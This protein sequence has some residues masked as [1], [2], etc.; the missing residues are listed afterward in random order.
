MPTSDYEQK[1]ES[2]IRMCSQAKESGVDTVIIHHPEV[3]G[4]N[5]AEVIESLNRLAT[6]DLSLRVVPPDQRAGSKDS[7]R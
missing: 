6:A 3:L 7:R 1:L 5:Y 4:D 2:F